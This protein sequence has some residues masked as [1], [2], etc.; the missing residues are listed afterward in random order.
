MSVKTKTGLYVEIISKQKGVTGSC[1]LVN[2]RFNDGENVK[3]LVDCGSI[4]G[5]GDIKENFIKNSSLEYDPKELLATIITH[6]HIDHCGRLPLLKGECPVITSK[7][8]LLLMKNALD[9]NMGIMREQAEQFKLKQPYTSVDLTKTLS[10]VKTLE[11]GESIKIHDRIKV[12]LFANPHIFGATMVL[13]QIKDRSGFYR[14]INLLFS[15]D[16]KVENRFLQ[17]QSL[18][19]WVKKLNLTI[20]LEGTYGKSNKNDI[21]YGKFRRNLKEFIKKQDS[22][23][24]VIVIPAFSLGRTPDVLYELKLMQDQGEIPSNCNIICD[25]NLSHSHMNTMLHNPDTFGIKNEMLDFKPKGLILADKSLR[26]ALTS[27]SGKFS[28]EPVIIVTSSGMGTHGPA[29]MYLPYFCQRENCLIHFTGYTVEESLGRRLQD[30]AQGSSVQISGAY[31]CLNATV[32]S[33][34][35]FSSHATGEEII[36]F[37]KD[38]ENLECILINHGEPEIKKVFSQR[39]SN[40]LDKK[41]KDI[42]IVDGKTKFRISTYGLTG[43]TKLQM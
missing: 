41:V 29:Q 22:N 35:E 39:V 28:N 21:T 23:N 40:E 33:T 13:I 38:F 36:E 17:L 11:F 34:N 9:D 8:T 16:Y 24:W 4:Q 19:D 31:K 10:K 20:F 6:A 5:E 26:M 42:E 25:G 27:T 15:G 14:E 12:T 30:T 3:F 43:K 7:G 37:L 32:K 1:T 18:P 2:V